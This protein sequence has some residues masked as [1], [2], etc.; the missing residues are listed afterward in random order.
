MIDHLD[1]PGAELHSPARVF[2]DLLQAQLAQ[3]PDFYLFSPDETTSNKLDAVF[4]SAARAWD[5]PTKAWDLPSD[6]DGHII[7][8]LSENTLFATM[9][10]HLLSGGSA[11]MASYEAFFPIITSQILQHLKFIQQATETPWRSDIAAVNLLSTSTCWRQDHNGFSHQSP[12]L[13]STLL[14]LPSRRVNCFFPVDDLSAAATFQQMLKSK[15]VVNLTTFNKTAEPR[16]IDSQHAKFQLEH[17]GASIFGFASD[18]DLAAR[19]IQPDYIFTAAGDIATREAL[20]AL[21][22]LRADLPQLKFRFVGLAALSY[23]AIGSVDHPL[24]QADFDGYFTQSVPIIANF[25]GYP[26]TLRTILAH[27]TNPKRCH[28]HGFIDRG[29]TTTPFE[30][31]SLNQASRYHLAISVARTLK[32]QDLIAKYHHLLDQN[33]SYAQ[34]HGLDSPVVTDFQF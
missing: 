27:Y 1:H 32:R 13:I 24:S 5:L 22:L 25:H 12:A 28:V 34:A 16:W 3:D 7:E 4:Q 2:G 26:D 8:L 23:A 15:N 14:A 30:M 20:Y 31:L 18:G 9:L 10:G 11:I 19:H 6:P 29:S 17:G 33:N 21:K